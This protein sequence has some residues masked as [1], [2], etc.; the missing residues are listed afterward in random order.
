LNVFW[1]VRLPP[2]KSSIGTPLAE[3]PP[4]IAHGSSSWSMERSSVA[5]MPWAAMRWVRS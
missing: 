1:S 2:M 5:T 4:Q 3:A